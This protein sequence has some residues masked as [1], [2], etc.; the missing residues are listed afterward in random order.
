MYLYA[1][2]FGDTKLG[3]HF[4]REE[5]DRDYLYWFKWYNGDSD[6][7]LSESAITV[8]NGLERLREP[9]VLEILKYGGVGDEN[10]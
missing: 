2:Q 3:K 10:K 1:N 9:N 7:Y 4:S 6:T 5:R 8:I